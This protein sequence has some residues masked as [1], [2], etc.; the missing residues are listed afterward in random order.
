MAGGGMGAAAGMGGG[1]GAA[2]GMGGGMGAAGKG[3]GG[4]SAA[5]KGSGGMGAAGM[6]GGNTT[7]INRSTN[8][9]VSGNVRPWGARP[10]YG[11]M[12]GGVALG[13]VIL[14]T[15]PRVVPVAPAAN[16]CWL[17]SDSTQVRG[18]WDYCTPP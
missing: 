17:W 2:A 14:A 4:M 8:V 12:L 6:G 16:M 9:N 18:Y 13:T 3:S 15:T 7:N 11:T 10:Y 1:M 5:G